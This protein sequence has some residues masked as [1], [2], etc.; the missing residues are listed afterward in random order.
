MFLFFLSLLF[1]FFFVVVVWLRSFVQQ[2]LNNGARL[3]YPPCL[4]RHAISSCEKR[5]SRRP[6]IRLLLALIPMKNLN[7]PQ[8]S[9]MPIKSQV[10][11]ES[12]QEKMQLRCSKDLLMHRF[13]PNFL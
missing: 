6:E 5:L 11:G 1:F 13:S 7:L 2:K 3:L 9:I 8:R 4:L 12:I 10:R